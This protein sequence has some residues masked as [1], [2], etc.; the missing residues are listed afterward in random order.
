MQTTRVLLESTPSNIE[1]A[2][3]SDHPG[4]FRVRFEAKLTARSQKGEFPSDTV[5]AV[6]LTNRDGCSYKEV[7]V[8]GKGGMQVDFNMVPLRSD[9]KLTDRV[10]FHFFF[11][12]VSDG[13]LKPICAAHMR[14]VD[15]ADKVKDGSS[16][17]SC[18]NFNSNSV[19]VAFVPS[20]EHS[21]GMHIDLLR[22]YNT[23]NITP[24]VL[25]N[26]AKH[27]ETIKTLDLGIRNGLQKHVVVSSENGGSMFQSIFTAHMMEDEATLY[28]LY[29][30]DFDGPHNVPPWLCTYLLA[31]TLH[32]NSVTIEQV[33]AM[34]LRDL[35]QFVSSYAQAP[36]R[37]ATAAPYT[38]DM[39]LNEDVAVC[40]TR[41]GTMLSEVF[42]RPFSH[43]YALVS[44]GH[45]SLIT[46]DCEGLAAFVRDVSNHLGWAFQTHSDDFK[47]TDTYVRYNNLMKAYFP[48]DLFSQM[49]SP[50]QNKLMDLVMFLG[51]LVANKTI[52]C[53]I[54][55]VSANGAS[56]G[57]EGN[58]THVQA[59][60]CASMVCNDPRFPISVMLEGTAC[61][62][63]DQ[64]SKRLVLNG[65][66][67]LLSEVANSLSTGEPF[68]TFM[69]RGRASVKIGFHVTHTRG[70][71]YR[72]AFCENDSMLASQIGCAPMQF[73]VDMEYLADDS[74]KVYMPVS[75]KGV[76][77]GSYADLKAYISAR[78]EEIH[79][80]FVDHDSIRENLRWAPMTQFKGCK[81]LK[82]GR[83][84]VTCLV[85]VQAA[86]GEEM[87]ALL[88][89]ATADANQFNSDSKYAQVGVMR[90]FTS[91]D[92]VSK[93]L[94]LYSDDMVALQA[95]LGIDGKRGTAT[96]AA[97]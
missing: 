23:G 9:L 93:L 16:F 61:L 65:K 79:L 2:N 44:N 7:A 24:S 3:L 64:Y 55:L 6:Y 19:S 63:D 58:Q 82:P 94:H 1:L 8:D 15:L 46:D 4:A 14:L 26:S 42:K 80:P 30:L 62:V 31:E 54:T 50:Y 27:L 77:Q 69:D 67:M 18:S 28:S 17:D 33:K 92:G 49:S 86:L 11:R 32:H 74:I 83:P 60:A 73:G 45:G 12:D 41:K 22:L 95:T 40:G 75:G 96:N 5:A 20:D 48:K 72:T 43:P 56:M 35:T 71:F 90:A 13:M 37:S 52:E 76:P 39:T 81:E 25:G 21:R 89:K 57:G 29:H 78:A 38:Q 85:H 68:N 36:M 87:D 53:K 10:K 88:C 34:D 59:H 70:S 51:E 84:Y 91:M 66:S 47:Q 97:V